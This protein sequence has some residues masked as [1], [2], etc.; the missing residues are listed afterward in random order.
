MN[1]TDYDQENK[2]CLGSLSLGD[3]FEG[4]RSGSCRAGWE[5]RTILKRGS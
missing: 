3:M 2:V 4:Q 1:I 5:A